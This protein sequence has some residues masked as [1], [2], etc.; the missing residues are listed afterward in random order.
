MGLQDDDLDALLDTSSS[1][2]EDDEKRIN[3]LTKEEEDFLAKV[4]SLSS[5]EEKLALLG[6]IPKV[7]FPRMPEYN[8]NHILAR[9]KHKLE[10]PITMKELQNEIK[11]QKAEI[12]ELK[13]SVIN[14][15]K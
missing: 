12:K 5:N 3:V 9:G 4:D 8:L 14:L 7:V 13:L 11:N 1:S 10:K 15:Q 2:S 6:T